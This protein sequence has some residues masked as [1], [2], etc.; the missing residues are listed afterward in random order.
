LPDLG[1]LNSPIH[2]T[3]HG[4]AAGSSGEAA[5]AYAPGKHYLLVNVSKLQYN[6]RFLID[7]KLGEFL[8]LWASGALG[9]GK[10]E[11]EQEENCECI[12]VPLAQ[13]M[14]TKYLA[15]DK[16]PGV[17]FVLPSSYREADFRPYTLLNPS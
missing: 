2:H 14:L 17:S 8:T 12:N 16:D 11:E 10:E 5:S 15:F 9:I 3:L 1:P 7:N 6:K 13:E 4:Q